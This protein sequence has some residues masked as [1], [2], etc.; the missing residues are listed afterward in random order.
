M[1]LVTGPDGE[2]GKTT[3]LLCRPLNEVNT[4]EDKIITIED[5]V[6]YQL[7]GVVQIP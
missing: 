6:E 1:V 3:T 5:P 7:A 4:K 2:A